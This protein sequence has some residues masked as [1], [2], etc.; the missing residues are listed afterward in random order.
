MA[1][2]VKIGQGDPISDFRS[3]PREFYGTSG[4]TKPTI[5]SHD[6]LPVPAIGP[7]FVEYDTRDVYE[8]YDG[9]NWVKKITY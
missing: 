8:T 4:D 1:I 9:T 6:N 7:I 3:E 5:A 2:T